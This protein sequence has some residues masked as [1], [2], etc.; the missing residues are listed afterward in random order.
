MVQSDP[1]FPAPDPPV[2]SDSANNW[3]LTQLKKDC[4]RLLDLLND[5]QPSIPTWIDYVNRAAI[6]IGRW[7]KT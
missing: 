4:E 6:Q 7:N 3:K 2:K 1:R 5:P